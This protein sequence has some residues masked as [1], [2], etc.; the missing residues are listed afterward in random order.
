MLAAGALVAAAAAARHVVQAS[1]SDA[2]RL[3]H[4]LDDVHRFDV[5]AGDDDVPRGMVA[6][7]T[8]A[9]CPGSWQR[10]DLA[11]GRIIVAVTDPIAV[12]RTIGVPLAAA[13]DRTHTHAMAPTM[14]LPI[15]SISG[16][17][18]SNNQGA[19]GGDQAIHGDTAAAPSGLPFVQLTACVRQ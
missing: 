10:A 17:D 13:E 8:G 14:K 11:S 3:A 6:Y 1:P 9:T 2:H 5:G 16:A 19:G 12:G 4:H 7:F 15:K 18:G